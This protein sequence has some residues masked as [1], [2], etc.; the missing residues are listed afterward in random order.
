MEKILLGLTDDETLFR[1]GVRFLLEEYDDLEVIIEASNGLELLQQLRSNNQIPEVLLLDLQMPEMDGIQT[2][3]QLQKEYPSIKVI[4]LTTHYSKAFIKNMIELGASS[5]LPK[6]SDPGEVL[7]TIREVAT[8]GFYY[9]DFVMEVIRENL[10]NKTPSRKAS[11]EIQFTA[12]EK[13]VLEL[14][15]QQLTT[16]EIAE[17]LFISPRTVDGHRNNLLEKTGSRNTAGLVVYA[18]ENEIVQPKRKW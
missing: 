3:E 13:E 18:Y 1:K 8:K 10:M 14:I 5:Y 17:K 7:R 16:S 11:L 2:T 12:R 4:I 6:N 15:C 9:N